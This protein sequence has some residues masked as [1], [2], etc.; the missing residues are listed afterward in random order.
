MDEYARA[1][2]QRMADE[3]DNEILGSLIKFAR[4]DAMGKFLDGE[5]EFTEDNGEFFIENL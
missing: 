4:R 5:E 2:T 1:A 3:I